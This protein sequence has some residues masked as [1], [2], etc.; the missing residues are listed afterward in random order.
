MKLSVVIVNYN[1][2]FYLDQCLR[3]VERAMEGIDGE[4]IVVD[5]HSSDGSVPFLKP[6]HPE[7]TFIE[8]LRNLGFARGNNL[9][10]RQA[11][12]EYVLLLNPDTI[13]GEDVFREAL[14]FA[15]AH[16]KSGAIGVRMLN[17]YGLRTPESRRGI[18][19]PMTS[20]YKMSGLCQRYPNHPKFGHYYMSDL[21]WDRPGEIE[22]VSGA[23]CLLRHEA[24]KAV[25]LLDEDFFMYGEDIDLSY[26]LLK[27]GWKNYY[28][29]LN[30]LHYK[31]ESTEKSSFRYVHVFYEAMLIFFRK[32]YGHLSFLLSVPIRLA[33][34]AKASVSLLGLFHHRIRKMLGFFTP[35]TKKSVDYQVFNAEDNAFAKILQQMELSDHQR[36]LALYYPSSRLMVT[37]DNVFENVPANFLG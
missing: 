10:I 2:K 3:S 9:A 21:P 4:V 8:S 6:R 11:R 36:Q 25:G 12:G 34:M 33:I 16:P 37:M 5:N 14:T 27:G 31:G 13:V 15:D 1:V 30:I 22:I 29:P 24:L 19:T 23:F 17:A 7:V 32:H 18:P 20:F 28:L 35:S 26:R